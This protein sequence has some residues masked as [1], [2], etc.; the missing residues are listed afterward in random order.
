MRRSNVRWI[1]IFSAMVCYGLALWLPAFSYVPFAS[2]PLRI[3]YMPGWLPLVFG[4]V[5]VLFM[6]FAAFSFLANP[7]FIVAAFAYGFG[8][9]KVAAQ[10]AAASV[11]LG[12]SFFPLSSM[13]PVFVPFSGQGE[14]I[15]HPKSEAGFWFWMA[16]FF[17]VFSGA[18][19]SH[20]R[21]KRA[22]P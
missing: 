1:A 6:E 11:S 2:A 7:V 17:I 19:I 20:Q 10:L 16:A 18:L 3:A 5:A 15:N 4:V 21:E 13:R 22:K 9:N 12:A 8:K 14:I